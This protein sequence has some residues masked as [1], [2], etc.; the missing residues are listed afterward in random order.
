MKA[1]HQL[2]AGYTYGDAISNEV[3]VL[4]GIFRKWGHESEIYCEKKRILPDLKKSTRDA[5]GDAATIR[6]DDVALLHLSIGS[7]VNEAFRRLKCRK[8]ILYHNITPPDYFRGL[9]EPVANLLAKGLDQARSLAGSAEVTMADSRFNAK[10][11]E[12]M[13]HGPT[14]VLPLVLDFEAMKNPVDRKTLRKFR[15][16]ITNVVFVGR[17]VPNKRLE[18]VLNAFYYFQK[19]V[20]PASRLIHVGSFAGM[21]QY[22]ALLLTRSRELLREVHFLGGIPQGELNAVYE[23]ARVFL[24][25]SEHEGFCIPLIEAMAHRVPVVAYDAG[26]VA[27]TMDG[28]GILVKRKE[29]D[30]IAEAMGKVAADG[31]VRE[32]VLK[33]QDNRVARYRAMDLEG[34]LRRQ[35]AGLLE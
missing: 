6:E 25:M 12:A 29:F 23:S 33:G 22:H 20:Q 28:A 19:Y 30:W 8:A 14:G 11:L 17:C 5:E 7:P 10:E 26:A 15:D 34:E 18:D 4:Q 1:I 32:A 27:E 21:E 24:C 16:G 9:Q 13:G 2:V 31:E 35:L 3:R